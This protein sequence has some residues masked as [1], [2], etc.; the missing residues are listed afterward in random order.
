[1]ILLKGTLTQRGVLLLVN[2]RKNHMNNTAVKI[3]KRTT[4]KLWGCR[5]PVSNIPS[6]SYFALCD[7]HK[8]K[9]RNNGSDFRGTIDSH[10]AAPFRYFSHRLIAKVIEQ[11]GDFKNTTSTPTLDEAVLSDKLEVTESIP[12]DQLHLDPQV[13]ARVTIGLRKLDN[14]G[15]KS[16]PFVDFFDMNRHYGKQF[17]EKDY[18]PNKM[19]RYVWNSLLRYQEIDRVKLL[20]ILVGMS[21]IYDN[22][23]ERMKTKEK[24]EYIQIQVAK[25]LLR[26]LKPFTKRWPGPTIGKQEFTVKPKLNKKM[27]IKFGKEALASVE[28]MLMGAGGRK[29]NEYIL[30]KAIERRKKLFITIDNDNEQIYRPAVKLSR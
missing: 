23:V 11:T 19:L 27:M 17:R 30:E 21:V 2:I 28:W 10:I 1:M 26:Q 7:V 9:K 6:G 3:I 20:A 14:L 4:C 18:S 22:D 24:P 25:M 29:I 5:R 13:I 12:P 8:Q 15:S 16:D